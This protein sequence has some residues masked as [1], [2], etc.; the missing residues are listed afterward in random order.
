MTSSSLNSSTKARER[1]TSVHTLFEEPVYRC[2]SLL[3]CRRCHVARS[4]THTGY[5]ERPGRA[6]GAVGQRRSK[7]SRSRSRRW[8]STPTRADALRGCVDAPRGIAFAACAGLRKRNLAYIR[9]NDQAVSPVH[10]RGDAPRGIAFAARAGWRKRDRAY[11]R[12]YH[13]SA[14]AVSLVRGLASFLS[15]TRIFR[16][17]YPVL[18]CAAESLPR[19]CW[20]PT[21]RG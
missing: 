10:G 14:A 5:D 11:V 7:R 18:R 15:A 9:C 16:L 17:C 4:V 19:C 21:S 8:T 2:V 12:R 1:R 13:Q 6:T 3:A 20:S